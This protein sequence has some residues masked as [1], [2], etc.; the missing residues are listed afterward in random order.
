MKKVL[1]IFAVSLLMLSSCSTK[2][3]TANET[4]E[5]N[6]EETT[7]AAAPA[8]ENGVVAL[9]PGTLPEVGDL[10][11]VI[12]CWAEWCGPCMQFKPTYHKVAEEYAGKAIF[13]AADIDQYQDLPQIY[14]FSAIPTIIILRKDKEPIMS[15]G[16]MTED[17]F[18]AMLD[19]A[20]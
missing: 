4:T 5:V 3:Q 18:K 17:E 19:A 11:V 9:E 12:D 7:E 10:P 15:T 20:L 2:T 1:S 16:A 14:N 8:T 6:V 13:M